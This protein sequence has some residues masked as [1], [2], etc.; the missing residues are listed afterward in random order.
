MMQN[1]QFYVSLWNSYLSNY[2]LIF[3]SLNTYSII[4]YLKQ[5]WNSKKRKLGGF[6]QALVA[7]LLKI[8][9]TE[10]PDT[11]II[12][13]VKGN[14]AESFEFEIKSLENTHQLC[15]S[16]IKIIDEVI[17]A[18][19]SEIFKEETFNQIFCSSSDESEYLIQCILRI[20]I[21]EHSKDFLDKLPKEVLVKYLLRKHY[22][23][24]VNALGQDFGNSQAVFDSLVEF[25][26][27]EFTNKIED[28]DKF[29]SESIDGEWSKQ[30][31]VRIDTII[32]FVIEQLKNN[33]NLM[34]DNNVILDAQFERL[35]RRVERYYYHECFIYLINLF[36][37]TRNHFVRHMHKYLSENYPEQFANFFLVYNEKI[38]F[39]YDSYNRQFF[40]ADILSDI[41]FGMI[42]IVS[43]FYPF[44]IPNFPL[45]LKSVIEKFDQMEI[46]ELINLTSFRT[47]L[48]D[49]FTIEFDN[50]FYLFMQIIGNIKLD[51][52]SKSQ[53]KS[54][55]IHLFL[56]ELKNHMESK[57]QK[58]FNGISIGNE[59]QIGG[60]FCSALLRGKKK[61]RAFFSIKGVSS[62]DSIIDLDKIKIYNEEWNFQESPGF[63]DIYK[64]NLEP[65]KMCCDIPSNN[66]YDALVMAKQ[67][68][69][70]VLSNI[71]FIYRTP[72]EK[73]VRPDFERYYDIAEI[74]Q[75][76]GHTS[77]YT[78][79]PVKITQELLF[80]L[81]ELNRK[82]ANNPFL[83]R[84]LT[85]F[86]EGYY[87]ITESS[88]FLFYWLGVET[89][90]GV[91][92]TNDKASLLP[93]LNSLYTLAYKRP[94][95]FKYL[96][97]QLGLS[98]QIK[99]GAGLRSIILN[100]FEQKDVG[101]INMILLKLLEDNRNEL[102]YVFRRYFTSLYIYRK[103][104]SIVHEG[105]S[106]SFEI[107]GLSKV[108]QKYFIEIIELLSQD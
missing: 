44:K 11:R 108:L 66:M 29:K 39:T 7:R 104:N 17:W 80:K 49:F 65:L 60:Y 83:Q 9:E 56:K 53:L 89:I 18:C 15:E 35:S 36:D 61:Y 1:C 27:R 78:L 84:S 79:W 28:I 88:E 31:R 91:I 25:M 51:K 13:K 24:I 73:K 5:Y 54:T 107:V 42:I 3:S 85:W 33:V 98:V 76:F 57:N 81:K 82:S 90:V 100:I 94:D 30:L 47:S 103:R 45:K 8:I 95:Y 86:R 101:T 102:D 21:E 16:T 12:K 50:N 52:I 93:P 6:E 46:S 34:R 77:L 48:Q 32:N 55:S 62:D 4:R 105:E 67:M 40:S 96:I 75:K 59:K 26:K 38:G 71:S 23:E 70:D 37:P 10:A 20:L 19:Q 43:K 22:P 92:R 97:G 74:P 69:Y 64:M 106:F 41:F 2:E 99:Q 87:S 68:G 72:R 14:I 58:E 63:S